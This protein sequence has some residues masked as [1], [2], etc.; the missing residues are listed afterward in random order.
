MILS[1]T[2]DLDQ[3]LRY[4][5][6]LVFD[7]IP[8]RLEY[9]DTSRLPSLHKS[10]GLKNI[11]ARKDN[12]PDPDNRILPQKDR[13]NLAVRFITFRRRTILQAMPIRARRM[14]SIISSRIRPSPC[15]SAILQKAI[16]APRPSERRCEICVVRY[17]VAFIGNVRGFVEGIVCVALVDA[18]WERVLGDGASRE[19]LEPFGAVWRYH[20]FVRLVVYIALLDVGVSGC[21][22]G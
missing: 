22:D 5:M 18:G 14:L 2:A 13:I 16:T 12:R 9:R 4:Q 21:R 17:T 20:V 1:Q 7:K 19:V 15:T 11:F 6:K 8:Y 3:I 10:N